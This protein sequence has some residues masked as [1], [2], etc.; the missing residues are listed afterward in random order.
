MEPRPITC[1]SWRTSIEAN[2][3]LSALDSKGVAQREGSMLGVSVEALVS[4]V[5]ILATQL[6][7][8]A[9]LPK[10][11]GYTN[12]GFSAAQIAMFAISFAV[13]ARLIKN[14]V[15]LGILIPLLSTAMPLASV[16]IGILFF[17]ETASLPRVA[18]LIVACVLVGLASR[19]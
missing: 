8:V 12:I 13:M 19:H 16:L 1:W 3:E 10:T 9:L 14:G 5:I 2:V 17:K 6:V 11:N 4:F 18:M 15:H 7:G